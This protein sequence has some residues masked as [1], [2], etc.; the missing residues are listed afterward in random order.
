MVDTIAKDALNLPSPEELTT[1]QQAVAD[2]TRKSV[3]LVLD[4]HKQ[5]AKGKAWET[6]LG[7]KIS[8]TLPRSLCFQFLP[9]HWT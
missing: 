6:I 9:H 3:L 2:I 5:Q 1:Y 4:V 7:N 8:S